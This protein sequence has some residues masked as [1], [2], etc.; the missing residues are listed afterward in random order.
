MLLIGQDGLYRGQN[1]KLKNGTQIIGRDEKC[2]ILLDDEQISRHH[3]QIISRADGYYIQDLNSRNGTYLNGQKLAVGHSLRLTVGNIV[4]VGQSEFVV[5]D[6]AAQLPAPLP[7]AP[8][9]AAQIHAVEIVEIR[10]YVQPIV[11]P[12]KS[13]GTAVLLA[14]LFGPL[15]MFY[16]TVGGALIMLIISPL[17]AA[18]TFGL[19]LF[20][21]WP[22]CVIWAASAASGYNQRIFNQ[23]RH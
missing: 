17:L 19:S 8:H 18:L 3:A 21:T 14:I 20:I 16:S 11:L 12:A 4:R 1:F 9:R 13:V 15:G 22:I 5:R 2:N 10:Q 23:F 6:S 7:P